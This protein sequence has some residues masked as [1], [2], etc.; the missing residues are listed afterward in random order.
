[1]GAIKGTEL[2][3]IRCPQ[4]SIRSEKEEDI[5]EEKKGPKRKSN[6]SMETHSASILDG[7][8]TFSV[9]LCKGKH[10]ICVQRA[11]LEEKLRTPPA[12]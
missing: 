12:F 11:K 1:M 3:L 2:G 5:E 10:C 6:I 8:P 9:E 7:K 4:Y